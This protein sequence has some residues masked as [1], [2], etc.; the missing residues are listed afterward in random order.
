M[1]TKKRWHERP[2]RHHHISAPILTGMSTYAVGG[3]INNAH[4]SA[5]YPAGIGGIATATAALATYGNNE[6]MNTVAFATATTGAA[7]GWLTASALV[8]AWPYTVHGAMSAIAGTVLFGG[9]YQ[10]LVKAREK[11]HQR[12]SERLAAQQDSITRNKYLRAFEQVGFRGLTLA[13]KPHED[14][15]G[16]HIPLALPSNGRITLQTLQTNIMRLEVALSHVVPN[17]TPGSVNVKQGLSAHEAIVTV[18][19]NDALATPVPLPD[20]HNEL[21]IC[22]PLPIGYRADGSVV[23]INWLGKSGAILG[24]RGSGKSVTVHDLLSYLLRCGD[25]VVWMADFKGGRTLRPYLI[26]WLQGWEVPDYDGGTMKAD[27]PVFDWAATTPEEGERILDA[28]LALVHYRSATGKGSKIKPTAKKQAVF[29]F[30]EENVELVKARKNAASKLARLLKL[31]RSEEVHVIFVTQRGTAE[32][33]GGGEARSQI[34]V[35]I[36]LRVETSGETG[37]IFPDDARSLQLHRLKHP[38]TMYVKDVDAD[39][40]KLRSWFIMD[41]GDEGDHNIATIAANRTRHR[42]QLPKDEV[43]A[44]GED[45]LKRWTA[46][47]AGHLTGSRALAVAAT[48]TPL[49]EKPPGGSGEGETHA[50]TLSMDL[51]PVTPMGCSTDGTPIGRGDEDEVPDDTSDNR[52]MQSDPQWAE[53]LAGYDAARPIDPRQLVVREIIAAAGDHGVMPAAILAALAERE[54]ELHRV[55]LQDWLKKD[56]EAHI[57]ERIELGRYVIGREYS[58]DA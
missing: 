31:C 53:F 34:D 8:P 47:R 36:G 39:P 30:L 28:G 40:E 42:G 17:L 56:K 37:H 45:Y 49:D 1:A 27:R 25:A 35:R 58:P 44:M 52:P 54:I 29:I 46:E 13:R 26:P 43:D 5:A 4:M 3:I 9:L 15:G 16:L 57:V 19:V 2:H 33:L 24:K 11:A 21:S 22:N 48:A 41:E 6:P 18:D 12:Y 38:G 51:K 10:W 20:D 7:T 32:G 23:S 55:T 50:P 14:K